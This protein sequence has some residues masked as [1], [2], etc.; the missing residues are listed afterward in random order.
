[1]PFLTYQAIHDSKC[2]NEKPIVPFYCF[3]PYRGTDKNIHAVNIHPPP[4][5]CRTYV[6]P[7]GKNISKMVKTNKNEI[8]LNALR[9]L[10]M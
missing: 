10:R 8:P 4:G 6:V 3:Y 2:G 7:G 5:S 1:M 9:I